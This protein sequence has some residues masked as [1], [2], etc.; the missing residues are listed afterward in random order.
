MKYSTGQIKRF[1]ESIPEK[2]HSRL[3]IHT[4]HE[5]AMKYKLKGVYIT[6]SHRKKKYRTWL[7]M[8]W[9]KIRKKELQLSMTIRSI[10][11]LL[12]YKSKYKY[13]LLAPVFDSLS[14]NYQSAFSERDL[15]TTLA[16][17]KYKVIARGGIALDK[18]EKAHDMGFAGIALYSGI[19]KMQNPL[20]EFKR[21]K[22]K[23]RE[24]KIPME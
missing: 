21:V 19:W 24:L 14:G 17:T 18:I 11:D 3:V 15:R 8:L 12:D 13:V 4:H 6:R 2:C 10:E 5:L 1:I 7:R 22:E 23:F 20:E 9:F 16:Q